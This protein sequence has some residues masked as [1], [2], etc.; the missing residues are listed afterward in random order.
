MRGTKFANSPS[1]WVNSDA[2]IQWFLK[3][4][5]PQILKRPLVLLYDGHLQFISVRVLERA[6]EDGVLLFP[7]PPHPAY[8]HCIEN[9][10]FHAFHVSAYY[11]PSLTISFFNIGGIL[12]TYNYFGGTLCA[13]KVFVSE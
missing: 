10:C 1:G 13:L 5:R 6:R 7:L 9:T 2:F 12:E 11:F 8:N 4:F 3:H